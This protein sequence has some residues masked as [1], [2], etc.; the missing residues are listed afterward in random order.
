M[1]R[2]QR[3][4]AIVAL[5]G[6]WLAFCTGMGALIAWAGVEQ[7]DGSMEYGWPVFVE[8]FALCVGILAVASGTVFVVGLIVRWVGR[9][10]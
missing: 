7:P 8:A 9:G 5:L 2:T 1:I 6:G 3:E 10:E 4:R